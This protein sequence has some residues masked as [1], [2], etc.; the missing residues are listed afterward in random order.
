MTNAQNNTTFAV[1]AQEISP[2]IRQVI[3]KKTILVEFKKEDAEYLKFAEQIK[4]LQAEQ[5]IYLAEKESEL[6]GEIK[7]LDNDIKEGIKAMTQGTKFSAKDV[8]AYLTSRAK[9]KVEEVI[10]KG[11]VFSVLEKELS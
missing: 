7:D 1:Y 2:L 3:K 11:D 9:D 10:L 8:K 5:K 4:E 6:I